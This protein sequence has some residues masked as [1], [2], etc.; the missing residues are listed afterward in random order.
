MPLQERLETIQAD[1]RRN[2]L[3]RAARVTLGS[4]VLRVFAEGTKA[5]VI[6]ALLAIPVDVLLDLR[7]PRAFRKWFLP[8]LEAV[9]R[10]IRR[11]NTATNS[12]VGRGLKWG[13]GTKVLCLY[14]REV[15]EN[16]RY[17]TDDQTARIAPLLFVPIDSIVMERLRED[18][19]RLNFSQICE[20]DTA[21][22]FYGVQH[23]LAAPASA[24]GVPRVW[25]DDAWA[26]V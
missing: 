3:R 16:S 20:I 18:G 10:A 8:Q 17:F 7:T 23:A 21:R 1:H 2:I 24:V 9:A 6:E 15:V 26:E 5:D 14:L 4:S 19:V 12:R 25:Y 13:H 11:K 22:K